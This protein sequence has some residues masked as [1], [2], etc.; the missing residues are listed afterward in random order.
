MFSLNLV[1]GQQIIG[2]KER[3]DIACFIDNSG[4]CS[5]CE[6]IEDVSVLRCPE[7]SSEDVRIVLQTQ[8]KS[9]A[10]LASIFLLYAVS[11]LRFG[12]SMRKYILLYQI[13]YV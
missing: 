1:Q 9:S 10:A 3:G 4:T 13:D 12:F 6:S 11:A 2:S 5:Q 8:A 7:W